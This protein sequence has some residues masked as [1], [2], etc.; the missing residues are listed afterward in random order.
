[1]TKCGKNALYHTGDNNKAPAWSRPAPATA[2]AT[3][4]AAG[5][6]SSQVLK[7]LQAVQAE[8]V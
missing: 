5:Y 7:G 4:D 1:M 2:T 8:P 6:L 3:A